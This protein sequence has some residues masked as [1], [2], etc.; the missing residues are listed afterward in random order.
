[1]G[2]DLGGVGDGGVDFTGET[3]WLVEQSGDSYADGILVCQMGCMAR[4]AW[5]SAA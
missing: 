3:D 4:S 1:M 2:W 5:D